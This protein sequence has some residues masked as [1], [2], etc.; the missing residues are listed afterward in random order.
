MAERLD[1]I[2]L[3]EGKVYG[4][5]NKGEL[6]RRILADFIYNYDED[7]T[8][9]IVRSSRKVKP[10]NVVT[11]HGNARNTKQDII[12]RA[13]EYLDVIMKHVDEKD[14]KHNIKEIFGELL[15]EKGTNIMKK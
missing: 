1:E 15:P 7:P 5:E 4:I 14:C 9:N 8:R 6:I 10:A 11:H 2:L 12:N 3:E 13:V